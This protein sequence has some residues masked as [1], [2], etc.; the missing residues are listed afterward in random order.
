MSNPWI[1]VI[2]YAGSGLVLISMLMSSVVKLRIINLAGSA[3]FTVYALLIRSYPTAL[4][5]VCLVGINLYHLLYMS[6]PTRQFDVYE[7][8]AD[9]AWLAHFLEHY[10][11]DIAKNFPDF[12][13]EDLRAD[14]RVFAVM[15]DSEAAGVLIGVPE[16]DGLTVT[17]DYATPVYRD[18]SVGTA[19]YAA[20]P[21]S[22]VHAL[23]LHHVPETHA[24]Y[25]E[26]MG[27]TAGADGSATKRLD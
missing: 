17:L 2:G 26:R 27:F 7:D 19:L 3:I 25:I 23:T 9:S 24:K 10:R 6:K 16:G 12:R 15:R 5:N 22:G 11:E 20:L 13:A 21:A 4:M 1:E 14:A 18:C 8:R